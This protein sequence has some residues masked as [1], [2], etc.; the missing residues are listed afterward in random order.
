MY[1]L[2]FTLYLNFSKAH[3]AIVHADKS[4]VTKLGASALQSA[5]YHIRLNFME[6]FKAVLEFGCKNQ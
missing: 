3:F 1:E 2:V 6:F 4:T 5:Y